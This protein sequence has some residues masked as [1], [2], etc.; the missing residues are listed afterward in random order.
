MKIVINAAS[1]KMGGAVSYITNLLRHLSQAEGD[2]EFL[3]F[4]PLET[5]AKLQG[6]GPNIRVLPTGIGH[7]G[8]AGRM[9]WEQVTLR[10]FLKQER[11]DALFSTANFAMF[12]CPVRQLLLVRNALYFSGIYRETFLPK[13]SWSYR[14]AFALRRRLIAQSARAADVV[15]TPTQ[16]MLDELRTCA[17]VKKAVVNPYGVAAP[18][19][20]NTGP[21]P[22]APRA[23][24]AGKRIVRLLFVSLYSEH[25]N[26]RT[27]LKALAILNRSGDTQFKLTTTADPAWPEA[28]VTVTYKDDLE[29]S[30]VPG[31][32]E[33]VDFVGPLNRDQTQGLY[34]T[35]DIFV[36]PSL[37][38]SF[39]YPMAE[40]MSHGLPVVAAETPVN[41]EMCGE[42][43]V[44]FSP[45]NAGD[46]AQKVMR[47]A[48]GPG[49]RAALGA[50]G[51]Q[52]AATQFSWSNHVRQ[53]IENARVSNSQE[54]WPVS[55]SSLGKQELRSS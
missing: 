9:W 16:A 18:E 3:V 17:E 19:I 4:L 15:M 44:Y 41:R 30:Q 34:T 47:V 8:M 54:F 42:S 25:K 11:A 53:L 36:F 29:L 24:E 28:V 55:A 31:I 7:A 45:V 52:R 27:L 1:A 37:T 13:H 23:E 46:L 49:L 20:T 38:E 12:R 6:L 26:L 33:H 21:E 51:T 14:L 32:R 35:A 50:N 2:D 40:A 39:G 43:A 10:R 5:A 48:A 22:A